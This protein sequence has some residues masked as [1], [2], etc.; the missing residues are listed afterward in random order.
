MSKSR[1]VVWGDHPS[2]IITYPG[3]RSPAQLRPNIYG[4][5]LF[6]SL[7]IT[8]LSLAQGQ[9]GQVQNKLPARTIKKEKREEKILEPSDGIGVFCFQIIG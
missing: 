2:C 5:R 1:S 7:K 6:R 4:P 9:T 8:E 3:H